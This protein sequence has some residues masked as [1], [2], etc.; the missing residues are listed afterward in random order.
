LSPKPKRSP[1]LRRIRNTGLLVSTFCIAVLVVVSLEVAV[2]TVVMAALTL[3]PALL[4]R[5]SPSRRPRGR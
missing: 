3:G 4:L 5:L 1:K 2:L